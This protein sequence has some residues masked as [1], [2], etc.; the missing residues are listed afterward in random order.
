MLMV[1]HD[2]RDER[3]RF[4]LRTLLRC[5]GPKLPLA[6]SISA[7]GLRN[8]STLHDPLPEELTWIRT[9]DAGPALLTR[10]VR[11]KRQELLAW[12]GSRGPVCFMGRGLT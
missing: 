11:R 4:G 1:N 12:A 10:K 9:L 8:T 5:G 2:H 3:G 6:P 7:D